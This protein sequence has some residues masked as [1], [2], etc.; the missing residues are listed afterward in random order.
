MWFKLYSNAQLYVGPDQEFGRW[1][2]LGLGGGE[3][4]M[5]IIARFVDN[6]SSWKQKNNQGWWSV[7]LRNQTGF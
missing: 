3:E 4:S 5:I 6:L 1:D 7:G 2:F